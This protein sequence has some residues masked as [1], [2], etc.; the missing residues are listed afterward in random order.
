M[1]L[2]VFHALSM[3]VHE[4]IEA[5]LSRTTGRHM[6][7]QTLERLVGLVELD[8]RSILAEIKKKT[9]VHGV[10]GSQSA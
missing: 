7:F 3:F 9:D 4:L 5:V 10:R 8:G 1:G 6:L 2:D